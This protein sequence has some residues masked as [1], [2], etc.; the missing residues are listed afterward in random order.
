MIIFVQDNHESRQHPPPTHIV[1]IVLWAMKQLS[2][3]PTRA[4]SVRSATPFDHRIPLY[5]ILYDWSSTNWFFFLNLSG[6][7]TP[8]ARQAIP[9]FLVG[10][11][12]WSA[13]ASSTHLFLYLLS[14]YV[15]MP[16]PGPR[17][18][19]FR[20]SIT[21]YPIARLSHI[22]VLP[23]QS[24][25]F[26]LQTILIS[27]L[28]HMNKPNSSANHSHRGHVDQASRTRMPNKGVQVR[29]SVY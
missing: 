25:S 5:L 6:L 10:Q 17:P 23:T 11:R 2:G 7:F 29:Q 19:I 1:T 8:L 20:L 26:S 27:C 21:F 9:F 12:Q 14:I 13:K 28:S 18:S 15:P 22:Y 4:V 16:K 3:L 24:L